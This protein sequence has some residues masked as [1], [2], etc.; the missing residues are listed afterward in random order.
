MQAEALSYLAVTTNSSDADSP[1][2]GLPPNTSPL[3]H[4][5]SILSSNCGIVSV[6]DPTSAVTVLKLSGIGQVQVTKHAT[7]PSCKLNF[8]AHT[9]TTTAASVRVGR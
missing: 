1:Y 7:D 9:F 5:W 3:L 6:Q 4:T 8:V 2:S